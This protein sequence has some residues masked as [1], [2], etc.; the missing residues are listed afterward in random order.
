MAGVLDLH[1]LLVL[2][3]GWA[4]YMSDTTAA[5]AQWAKLFSGL[6]A[7]TLREWYTEL[8]ARGNDFRSDIS[9]GTG[10]LPATVVTLSDETN[11]KELEPMGGY[12]C[13][14]PLTSI[15]LL[16][17]SIRV[18]CYNGSPELARAM[19]VTI[20][21]ILQTSV[22]RL[23]KEGYLDFQYEGVE[24]LH[25]EEELLAEEKGIFTR[26]QR[27]KALSETEIATIDAE[28]AIREWWVLWEKLK[29]IQNPAEHQTAPID[30]DNPLPPN[31]I[32]P[33][34]GVAGEAGGVVD[35]DSD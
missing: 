5:Y 18:A 21:A 7:E 34:A 32:L 14:A 26:V 10:Q 2:Q 33:A 16:N 23:Q 28:P 8:K 19:H 24:E 27:W 13:D 15:L 9:S 17:Q 12:V 29:T 4:Y 35:Y 6:K 31:R 3:N 20:R 25:P 22:R 1:T 11:W 30:P